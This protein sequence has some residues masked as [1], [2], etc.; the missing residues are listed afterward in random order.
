[1]D[2]TSSVI[3]RASQAATAVGAF[4]VGT[5]FGRG[6][7]PC[8][9]HCGTLTCAASPPAAD[10][11]QGHWLLGAALLIALAS[12]FVLLRGDRLEGVQGADDTG[13]ELGA[14]ARAQVAARRPKA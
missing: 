9:V 2:P 1:M 13:G 4:A 10:D 14:A 6:C 11:G 12:A 8:D 7:P 5:F 3:V